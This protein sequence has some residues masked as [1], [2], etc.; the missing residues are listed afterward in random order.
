MSD[1]IGIMK[2]VLATTTSLDADK[3]TRQ[4]MEKLEQRRQSK[5]GS[6]QN[7]QQQS[8]RQKF[9]QHQSDQAKHKFGTVWNQL[10]VWLIWGWHLLLTI[11]H[12][13]HHELWTASLFLEPVIQQLLY[14][15]LLPVQ[16]LLPSSLLRRLTHKRE[17]YYDQDQTCH[18]LIAWTEDL[19]MDDVQQIQR[20]TGCTVNDVMLMI[21]GRSVGRYLEQQGLPSSHQLRVVIPLSFRMPTDWSMKNVVTGNMVKLDTGPSTT[22]SLLHSIHHR[23]MCVKRSVM[24]F[25]IYHVVV[26]TL[27][28]YFPF[29]MMPLWCQH[30]YTDLP[31]AVFTNIS[32]PTEPTCF[33][34][35]E[36]T[37]FHVLP[38]QAGKGS[39]SVGLVSYCDKLNVSM[40][41]DDSPAYP[42]LANQLCKIFVAEFNAALEEVQDAGL[43]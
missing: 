9:Q 34:G 35:Q 14:A 20:G 19:A 27:L 42:D 23:M 4:M 40:L 33:G 12:Q 18:K 17:L 28:R 21:F 31:H 30:W 1:G 10:V 29:L 11:K 2:A 22:A 37:R 26:Q 39:I 43:R 6:H 38:P 41:T 5:D 24:P 32:G 16:L 7:S 25:A 15:C 36:M 3:E 13:V 8:V